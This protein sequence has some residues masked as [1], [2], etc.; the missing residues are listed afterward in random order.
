MEDEGREGF[1]SHFRTYHNTLLENHKLCPKIQDNSKFWI[2]IFQDKS[3]WFY[4]IFKGKSYLNN[5]NF[6]AKNRD[7]RLKTEL[8]QMTIIEFWHF[9]GEKIQNLIENHNKSFIFG[10]KI[11]TNNS[12]IFSE[13]WFFGQNLKFSNSVHNG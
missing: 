2:W 10:T 8:S 1:I 3:H 4:R 7:L 11:Q 6:R 13:N 5:L 12:I 9:F